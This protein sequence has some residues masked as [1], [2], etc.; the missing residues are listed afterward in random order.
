MSLHLSL[1]AGVIDPRLHR[2]GDMALA[3]SATT[4]PRTMKPAVV[5]TPSEGSVLAT[6]RTAPAHLSRRRVVLPDPVAFK[7]A[8]IL[9]S[10]CVTPNY[11]PA[12]TASADSLKV[13]PPSQSS[14]AAVSSPATNSTWSSSG[15]ARASP[16]P[17]SSPPTRATPST[18]SSWACWRCP[19]RTRTGRRG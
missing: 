13:T 18:R 16:P 15:R 8:S 4:Q 2:D 14:S 10:C 6:A 12:N 9:T 11:G 3:R 17:S 19:P 1:P 5:D 7:Y